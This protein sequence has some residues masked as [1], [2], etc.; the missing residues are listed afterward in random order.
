LLSG[1]STFGQQWF[2]WPYHT[3][4]EPLKRVQ[5]LT[6]DTDLD[7]LAKARLTRLATLRSVDSYFHRVR[8]NLRFAARPGISHGSSGQSWDRY[9]LYRPE[10]MV[11]IIEIYRFAHNWLGDRRTKE[12]PA[13]RL[14]LAKGKI[15]ERDLFGGSA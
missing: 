1:S 8:S 7:Y 9:Y 14:G 15:Y 10:L 13:M 12:T 5:L 3:K 2:H 6:D 11:K 4:S